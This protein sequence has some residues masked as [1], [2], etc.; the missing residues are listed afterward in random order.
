MGRTLKLK[1][2]PTGAKPPRAPNKRAPTM[3][4]ESLDDK[5]AVPKVKS[6]KVSFTVPDDGRIPVLALIHQ[7]HFEWLE[8]T[9][10]LEG[11]TP[12]E[13]LDRLVRLAWSKD[14]SKGGKFVDKLGGDGRAGSGRG[15]QGHTGTHP[16]SQGT[17]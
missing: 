10:K 8:R 2:A 3:D 11:R 16:A 4:D 13:F 12:G 6:T 1:T 9:A 17:G 15:E 14:P 5:V 7:R